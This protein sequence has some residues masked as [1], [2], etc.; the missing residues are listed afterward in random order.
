M[1]IV[2]K[3]IGIIRTPYKD[4]APYQPITSEKGVFKIVLDKK[5]EESLQGLEEFE[6][7]YLLYHLNMIHDRPKNLVTPPWA[8]N[9]RVGLFASRSP[10]RPNPIGLSVV[11]L[12][13]IT[14]N[15]LYTSGIDV[16]DNTP[17]LD[18]KP[19][20]KELDSKYDSNYGWLQNQKDYEHLLLHIKG[21]PHDY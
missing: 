21:I 2:Y 17:L 20:I 18:I 16:F 11:K 14:K 4:K 7:I 19:Y 9:K 3:P 15:I 10:N 12:R 13:G 6:Y 5:Y 1:E 8:K